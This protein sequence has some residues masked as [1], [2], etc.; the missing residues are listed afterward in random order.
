M[1][2]KILSISQP[3]M[4]V[5]LLALASSIGYGFQILGFPETNIVI[6]YLLAIQMIAWLTSGFLWG[7][8]ASVIGTFIFNYFFTKP[9]LSFSINDPSY[10]ITFIIMTITALVTSTIVSHAKESAKE[11][12]QKE[13]EAKT[14]YNLT[15][16]L[17]YA[18]NIQEI[19]RFA[20]HDISASFTCQ[21]CCLSINDDKTYEKIFPFP[22]PSDPGGKRKVE[23]SEE[24]Q[25]YKFYAWP[26]YGHESLLG[27]VEIPAES[28][29][30]MNDAQ[31]RLLRSMMESI[32]LAMDRF[33]ASEQQIKSRE[34]TMQERYRAN[35][36]RAIS[37][38]LRTPL[39][40]IMGTS[41]IIMHLSEPDD[42]RHGLANAIHEDSNWLH[43]LVENILSLTRL[44]E[45]GLTIVKHQEAVEEV[46]GGAIEHV[47][48]HSSG[49]IF[50]VSVPNELLMVPMNAKLIMQVLI[51]LLDNAVKHSS[52][53]EEISIEV[54]KDEVTKNAVF[55][56]RDQ[57]LGISEEDM[58]FIFQ[59]F[60]TSKTQ[61]VDAK[62]GIGLGLSICDA[63]I[64]AHGGN[65]MARNRVET[66][67][68]EFTFTIPLM[69]INH[70]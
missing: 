57:G 4:M 8:L 44:E 16:H 45:G 19:I 61:I 6:I 62:R 53:D 70:E 1:K 18:N 50:K 5:S 69:E 51:N 38:D 59:Q 23:F 55:K 7:I 12:K 35:L 17:T 15:N 25:G 47:K 48:K 24:V 37:H 9:Y 36:L 68:A 27:I 56:I 39:S 34:E 67:G 49:Y 66:R 46:L 42:P 26:I 13:A 14:M 52:H 10:M 28:A 54:T 64:K 22:V 32:A 63:I 21:A 43:S 58:P 41:E 20:A 60:Y 3:V 11:A 29:R 2:T 31:I 30:I 33:Y 65:I 40:A